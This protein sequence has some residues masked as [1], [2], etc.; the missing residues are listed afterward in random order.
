MNDRLRS[1]CFAAL[2]P[3]VLAPVASA[4]APTPGDRWK[5]TMSYTSE[6]LPGE[7]DASEM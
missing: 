6:K 5:T 2:L 7:C 4:Q 1:L 3:L